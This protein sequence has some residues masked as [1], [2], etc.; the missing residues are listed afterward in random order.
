[1][2]ALAFE[3]ADEVVGETNMNAQP[4][5]GWCM[6]TGYI[7]L[8]AE[9]RRRNVRFNDSCHMD[10]LACPVK[11]KASPVLYWNDCELGYDISKKKHMYVHSD[12]IGKKTSSISLEEE[13]HEVCFI[14]FR[15]WMCELL[16]RDGWSQR[17]QWEATNI[18]RVTITTWLRWLC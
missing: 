5:V 12:R 13:I 1:M 9:V 3:G 11:Q 6:W 17:D 16:D 10:R 8:K 7:R 14:N 4:A 15:K 18:L 2:K